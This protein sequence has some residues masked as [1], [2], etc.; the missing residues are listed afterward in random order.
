MMKLLIIGVCLN[1]HY[2]CVGQ[3]QVA[4]PDADVSVDHP[5]YAFG[6]GPSVFIDAAH[7][8]FHT[9]HGRYEPFGNLL[10]NDGFRVEENFTLFSDSSLTDIDVL[11]IANADVKANGISFTTDEIIALKNFVQQG[12]SM[13]LIADHIPFPAAISELADSF[14]IHFLNVF[15]EDDGSG[16]FTKENDGLTEDTLLAG[17]NKLRSFGGSAFSITAPSYRPLM[18]MDKG[19]TMQ[20][21]TD[22]GLSEK[23]SAEGLLQGAVMTVGKGKVAVFGEAAMFTAQ[24]GGPGNKRFGFN[25]KGAE[26]N[27]EFILKVM[28]WLGQQ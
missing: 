16:I 4:D 9:A 19:W 6:K 3:V 18:Q 15:A 14:S 10:R 1:L 13:M 25:A 21:M 7:A 27:K 8:N 11:I 24:K 12:G 22:H 28:R 20:T 26:Q 2:S 5:A 17:I 23:T